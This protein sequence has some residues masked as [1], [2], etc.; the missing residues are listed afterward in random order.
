MKGKIL[1]ETQSNKKEQNYKCRG[2]G[3]PVGS[4]D[5]SVDKKEKT[6]KD[7]MKFGHIWES[8]GE[9]ELRCR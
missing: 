2:S 6:P 8:W 3:F 9:I 5:R 1:R 4:K 7:A